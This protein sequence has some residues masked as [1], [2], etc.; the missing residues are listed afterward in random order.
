[1]SACHPF[2]SRFDGIPCVNDSVSKHKISA[3]RLYFL[4]SH[5]IFS[6]NGLFN[7]C[8]SPTGV[9]DCAVCAEGFAP[10]IAYSCRECS[11]GV[12][13]SAVAL[14]A[15]LV[16]AVFL[17]AALV[18]VHLG[19]VVRYNNG[20]MA[21]S[22]WKQKCSSC[23]ASLVQMIPFTAIKIVVTVWQIIS[24]VCPPRLAHEVPSVAPSSP[25]CSRPNK[26]D[27]SRRLGNHT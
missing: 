10:G 14:L 11:G 16:I 27:N 17:L 15:G 2:M 26:N 24:Q 6:L 4:Y 9:A 20:K 12:T 19:S 1:M 7:C 21:Q 13:T 3:P 25:Q 18:L 23:R 5:G 8:L 22:S